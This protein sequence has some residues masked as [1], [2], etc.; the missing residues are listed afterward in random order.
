M[1]DQLEDLLDRAIAARAPLLDERHQAACRLFA[2]FAEG[3]PQ[4][5]I[6]LYATTAVLHN[7]ASPPAE[8]LPL[9]EMA[10]RVLRDRLPWLSGVVLKTRHADTPEGQAGGLIDGGRASRR[11]REHGV[12]YAVDLTLNRDASLY[13]DTRGLR[14]WLINRMRG[15]SVLNTFAYTGSLGV[16]AM[17]GGARRVVQLDLSRRF[18]TMAKDS[19]TLNG[20]PIVKADFLTGDFWPLASRLKRAGERFDCVILDP[21]IFAATGN[22]VVDL[23]SN[24]ARLINKLRPLVAS[25]GRLV[26]INNALFLS[27]AAYMEI[28]ESVCQDGYV[29]IA[30]RIDAPE[31][32]AGYPHTRVGA[33]VSDPAPFNHATKIAVLEVR[34]KC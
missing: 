17:A 3:C 9:V 33:P 5:A 22:G 29:R 13:L 12:W 34:H 25:G 30:E 14:A 16:A 26:A 19:Y 18:L 23:A 11:V 20:M 28:L 27:G 7:Y 1:T 31:D 4:L 6:D 8:G 10:L 2:G 32:C 21:P 15:L 24:Y